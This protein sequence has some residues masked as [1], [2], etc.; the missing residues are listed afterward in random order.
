[1][2]VIPKPTVRD[3]FVA[4]MPLWI[5][6]APF[7]VL[8]ALQAR[9]AGL[10]FAET[11]AMS[12]FVFAGASQFT[13]VTLL[14]GGASAV[15]II[16]TTFVV[17]LRHMLLAAS[18]APYLENAGLWRRALLAF[19][20]TDESYALSIRRF[21]EGTGSTAYLLGTNLSVYGCW[22]LSTIAGYV[23]GSAVPDPTRYGLDLIFPLTFLGLLIPL[24]RDRPAWAATLSAMILALWG[25]AMLPGYWY[26][27]L[28][29]IGGSLVGALLEATTEHAGSA[30]TPEGG[31]P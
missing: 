26:L 9:L 16:I 21:Q 28:A 14:A 1:M 19:Q 2:S 20:L 30:A 10:S 23:I 24:L 31:A 4:L 6:I 7:G 12:L 27:L 15:S 13:A 8:Y 11:L 17:N 29:G 3:G 5:A 22:Q 18:I 25:R